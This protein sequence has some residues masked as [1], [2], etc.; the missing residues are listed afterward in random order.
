MRRRDQIWIEGERGAFDRFSHLEVST[1]L[2]GEA[3]C[4][5]AVADDR[6]WRTLRELL[7]PGREYRVMCNGLVQFTGR[8]DCDELPTTCEDGTTI[9][10]VMRTRLADTRVGTADTT[11]RTENTSIKKFILALYAQH[12]FVESDFLFNIDLD[13]DLVTGRKPGRAAPVDLEPLQADKA[14]VQPT[15]TTEAA[16]KRHLE[17]HHLMLWEGG[18]GLICVGIPND[19][20]PPFYRFEQRPGVCN[21]RDARPVR[22]WGDIPSS[23]TIRGGGLGGSSAR[24]SIQATATDFD[25]E[26]IAADAGH[27]RRPAVLQVQGVKDQARAA[28]QAR[29]E[30]AMRSR[31]KAAWEIRADDWTFWDGSRSTPFAIATT[32]EVDSEM[33][34]GTDLNG[35]FLV[36]GVRKSYTLDEGAQASLTLLQQGLI[37]PTGA[38]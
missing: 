37:N 35:I 8:V 2:F 16:A 31:R 4:T 32:A 30:L 9:Q 18:S 36:T 10:V 19:Q 27:F 3:Q 29:R 23:I 33:H 25:L 28:A 14:K 21:F 5:M 17:R 20:Q 13:R 12:G 1:D 6:A 26:Q 22:D 11:V 24:S 7:N 34:A 15:E 38:T